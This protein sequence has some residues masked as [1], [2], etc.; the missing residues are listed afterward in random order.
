M[1]DVF[2]GFVYFNARCQ[3]SPGLKLF[4]NA[5]PNPC[6]SMVRSSAAA[7]R[8]SKKY[9]VELFIK[10]HKTARKSFILLKFKA[11][12]LSMQEGMD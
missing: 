8:Q 6:F 2:A 5:N 4:E 12:C 1:G 3:N 10:H 11:S 7:D 9:S